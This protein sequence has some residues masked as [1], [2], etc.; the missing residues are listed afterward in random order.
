MA[1]EGGTTVTGQ[2]QAKPDV[3]HPPGQ[4]P[5]TKNDCIQNVSSTKARDPDLRALQITNPRW[6]C[7]LDKLQASSLQRKPSVALVQ[8][9]LW[10]LD[11]PLIRV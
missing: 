8:H 4:S 3:Q 7:G 6:L 10:L 11:E 2:V 9:S 1:G 5:A